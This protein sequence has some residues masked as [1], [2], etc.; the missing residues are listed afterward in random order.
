MYR[1]NVRGVVAVAFAAV[2]AFMLIAT[3][4]A[5]LAGAA[6]LPIPE[7]SAEE[8]R[9]RARTILRGNEFREDVAKSL[10][11]RLFDWLGDHLVRP[12][13]ESAGGNRLLS[14]FILGLFA[15]A[16]VYVLSRFRFG[17]VATA[18]T[19]STGVEVD[20]EEDR[21]AALWESEAVEFEQRG[22]W[23]LALRAR[24]RWLLRTLIENGTLEPIPGRTP[25]EYRDDFAAGAPTADVAADFAAATDLFE[26]AWYANEPT[27]PAENERFRSHAARVREAVGA[28]R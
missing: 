12:I 16:L 13:T 9:E 1:P 8:A 21:A 19:A 28:K 3:V 15:A 20:L 6:E 17:R 22:E 11:E 2:L 24:Y 26:L 5:A 23:K 27:G 4:G 7:E 25:G 14:Y 10:R 18:S